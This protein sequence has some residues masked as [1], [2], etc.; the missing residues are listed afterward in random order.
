MCDFEPPATLVLHHGTS[1]TVEFGCENN[2]LVVVKVNGN[3]GDYT[4]VSNPPTNTLF[5][6]NNVVFVTDNPFFNNGLAAIRFHFNILPGLPQPTDEKI[7]DVRP[8]VDMGS[9]VQQ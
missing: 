7:E 4:L 5:N 2:D 9:C 3:K 6:K 8:E 1:T